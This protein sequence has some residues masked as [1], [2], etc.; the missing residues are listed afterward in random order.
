M[1]MP[2]SSQAVLHNTG[3]FARTAV[4]AAEA[5]R[6]GEAVRRIAEAVRARDEAE[7]MLAEAV[8]AAR[9][10]GLSWAGIGACVGITGE[11]VRQRYGRSWR[12]TVRC[13]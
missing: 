5:V 10:A 2:C 3:T 13:S 8:A 1:H 9:S 7:R 4:D 11:A 12:P 6:H